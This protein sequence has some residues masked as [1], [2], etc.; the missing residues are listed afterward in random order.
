MFF[1]FLLIFLLLRLCVLWFR[2]IIII[3]VVVVY[4]VSVFVD[5][6]VFNNPSDPYCFVFPENRANRVLPNARR[7]PLVV[8]VQKSNK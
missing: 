1:L 7:Q 4:F 5:F 6:F 8:T 3:I 2:V